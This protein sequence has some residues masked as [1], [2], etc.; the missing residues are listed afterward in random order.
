MIEIVC[1]DER[2]KDLNWREGTRVYIESDSQVKQAR[3]HP[4]I[5]CLTILVVCVLLGPSFG[6]AANQSSSPQLQGNCH[7]KKRYAVIDYLLQ[8]KSYRF[9]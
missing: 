8:T 3:E 9:A 4:V 7:V 5:E 6:C 2:R 1:D